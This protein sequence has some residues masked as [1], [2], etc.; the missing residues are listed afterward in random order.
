MGTG[1]WR[2][3]LGSAAAELV[4]WWVALLALWLVL[5]TEVDVLELAVGAGCGLAGALAAT[6][7][8][9]AAGSG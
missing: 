7:A 2:G 1:R 6:A 3:G 8:R 9:R 4:C 5:I